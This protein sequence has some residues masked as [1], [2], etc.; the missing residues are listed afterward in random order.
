MSVTPRARVG[1]VGTGWWAT[2]VHLPSL[3]SDERADLVA[4]ADADP[5]RARVVG[6]R[7]GVARVF[8]D[9]E[10]MLEERLDVVL[11]A[12]PPVAHFAPARDALLAGADVLI[13][14]PMVVDSAQGREL[15]ALAAS[16]GRRL[17]VGYP[18][19]HSAHTRQLAALIADGRLGELRLITSLHAGPAGILYAPFDADLIPADSMFAPRFE[20]YGVRSRGGGQA[21]GQMTHSLSLMLAVTG[22][23]P[24][25]VSAYTW[26]PGL[27][28]DLVDAGAISTREGPLATVAS[29]GTVP[30]GAQDVV[31]L[32]VFGSEGYALLDSGGGEL[33]VVGT[34]AA[35]RDIPS[36]GP[37]ERF[38][39]QAPA[40]HLV[41]AFLDDLAPVADGELGL[42]TVRL[43]EALLESARRGGPTV[44][45]DSHEERK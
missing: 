18:Y 24:V 12:T 19:L 4:I 9:H 34:D 8:T 32:N 37:A 30:L 41:D 25:E 22:I 40:R 26:G 1:V 20:T 31:Q 13:E 43:V 29:A 33:T 10:A 42:A 23:H 27:E 5:E 36:L 15:V 35:L 16:A 38:P 6:E 14:K 39:E 21:H 11:V 3:A 2:R 45:D 28:V 17:H 7:F 44:M